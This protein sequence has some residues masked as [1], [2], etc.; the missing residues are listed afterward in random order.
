MLMWFSEITRQVDVVLRDHS[1]LFLCEQ[2]VLKVAAGW[3]VSTDVLAELRF[4]L[5]ASYAFHQQHSKD[6][7]VDLIQFTL[8]A[9]ASGTTRDKI[10][11]E[12][13]T[14]GGLEGVGNQLKGMK[15]SRNDRG[16]HE[17]KRKTAIRK[18]RK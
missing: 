11:A 1:A 16:A 18:S 15:I 12:Q 8:P 13:A 2:H 5:S 17:T 9:G 7:A 4:D 6:I 14:L 10:R 3:G